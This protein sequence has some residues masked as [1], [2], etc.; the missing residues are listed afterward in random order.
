M[1]NRRDVTTI[2]I[3][4]LP[5]SPICPVSAL[6]TLL[7]NQPGSDNHPLFQIKTK[8]WV[9]LTDSVTRKH[10]SKICKILDVPNITYHDFRRSGTTWAFEH[11]VPMEHI[12]AHG[13]WKSD[14]V[15]TYISSTSS[16]SAA[17]ASK[18]QQHLL[19]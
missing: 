15:W 6:E 16:A 18:F 8:T 12:K 14:A 4:R 13:T 1:Q 3:P 19:S 7:G 11:G 2:V 10:L 17:L 9:P 5:G